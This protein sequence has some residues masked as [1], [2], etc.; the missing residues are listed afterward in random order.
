MIN[1][2]TI[3]ETFNGFL[4][5]STTI[6]MG[7]KNFLISEIIRINKKIWDL[8]DIARMKELGFEK[9]AVT[10][11]EIDKNNQLRNDTIQQI[12]KYIELEFTNVDLDD[13]NKYYSESPG[14]VIDR[15]S[16]MFIR[17]LEIQKILELIKEIELKNEYFSK[18]VVVDEQ[19]KQIGNFLDKYLEKINN[20]E[21]YFRIQKA[22]KIYNDDRV[23][24]YIKDISNRK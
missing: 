21:C 22:V 23:R 24:S 2:K 4:E 15:I 17:R 10:K 18:L 1:F 16:I 19:I 12:D 13:I 8:E 11:S 14:M 5:E 6:E 3:S 20:K 9:I 7:I